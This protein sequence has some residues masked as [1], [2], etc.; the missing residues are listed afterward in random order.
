MVSTVAASSR[1][2]PS[3]ALRSHAPLA[4]GLGE[5]VGD[6]ERGRHEDALAGTL[7]R[8]E[9]GLVAVVG[10]VDDLDAVLDGHAHR[11]AAPAMGAHAETARPRH[12]HG[13]RDLGGGHG[14]QLGRP[15]RRAE[16]TR[17]I[18]LE[19]VHAFAGEQPADP[20]DRVGAVGHPAEGRRLVVRQVEQVGVAQAAGHGDLGPV[21]EQARAGEAA[22]LD[23]ALDHHVEARLGRRGG[24]RARVA[25][26]QHGARVAKGG[27]QVLLRRQARH[28]VRR[29]VG[30]AEVRVRLDQ[31]GHQRGPAAVD[32]ALAGARR[33]RLL[34]DVGDPVAVHAYRARERLEAG[35]VQDAYVRDQ[36]AGHVSRS[37]ASRGA[38]GDGIPLASHLGTQRRDRCR[39]T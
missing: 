17:E 39:P 15:R 27:E 11:V 31:A 3:R 36:E 13:R 35:A 28:L 29:D 8:V 12:L 19:Q 24:E 18:Q 5:V 30:E 26:V 32:D 14:R 1:S 21:G 2:K 23:L 6:A 22:R 7:E 33:R 16:I 9:R 20:A 37:L 38:G 10:V 25:G 4:V 34:H